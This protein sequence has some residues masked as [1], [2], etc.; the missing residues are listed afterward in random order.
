MTDEKGVHSG[1]LSQMY[2]NR[3]DEYNTPKWVTYPLSEAIDGFDL[4]PCTSD[5]FTSIAKESYEVG[6]IKKGWKGD[7]W[8]NPPYSDIGPWLKKVQREIEFGNA[9]RVF[10][11]VPYRTQTQWFQNNVSLVSAICFVE[12]CISFGDS[13]D[14]A[15]FGNIIL[16]YG[17]LSETIVNALS[18]IGVTFTK[19]D[20]FVGTKGGF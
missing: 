4:D 18:E 3:H 1:N 13:D 11:L 8:L 5:E 7:V 17:E 12:G 6:G 2:D 16:Y 20:W 9:D 15:P 10:A 19:R 14:T